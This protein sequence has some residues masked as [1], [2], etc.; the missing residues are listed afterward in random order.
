MNGGEVYCLS[1][2]VGMMLVWFVNVSSL[3]LWLLVLCLMVYRLVML[4]DVMVLYLKLSV[5]RCL[6]MIC[7]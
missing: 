2:L 1:G 5:V 4:C 3:L 7:W 6:V